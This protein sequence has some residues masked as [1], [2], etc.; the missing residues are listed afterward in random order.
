MRRVNVTLPDSLSDIVRQSARD[1][2]EAEFIRRAIAETAVRDTLRPELS[3]LTARLDRIE[4]I[5]GIK[6]RGDPKPP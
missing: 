1:T 3:A 6:T 2:S 4:R 5:L